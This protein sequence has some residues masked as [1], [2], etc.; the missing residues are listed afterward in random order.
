M[1]STRWTTGKP[2][3]TTGTVA[4]CHRLATL[5][6]AHG[7]GRWFAERYVGTGASNGIGA[8]RSKGLMGAGSG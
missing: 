8:M 7:L 5:P 6:P 1:A 2:K 4:S 3:G